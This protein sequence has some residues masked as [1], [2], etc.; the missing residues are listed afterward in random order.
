MQDKAQLIM[1]STAK[2][3]A[4]RLSTA[5]AAVCALSEAELQE[6][7]SSEEEGEETSVLRL[8]LLRVLAMLR[9][10]AAPAKEA[11]TLKSTQKLLAVRL[12]MH[13]DPSTHAEVAGGCM[14]QSCAK[15]GVAGCIRQ[16]MCTG[17]GRR[18]VQCSTILFLL[19]GGSQ[20]ASCAPVMPEAGHGQHAAAAHVVSEESG[21][22]RLTLKRSS[23]SAVQ[24]SR[25]FWQPAGCHWSCRG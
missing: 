9:T 18:P 14:Q 2:D 7:R 21:A 24:G 19:A 16:K 1:A 17:L 12:H 15:V 25:L 5:V 13:N 8:A 10:S 3:L 23:H 22:E 4:K 20:G 11:A 6:E